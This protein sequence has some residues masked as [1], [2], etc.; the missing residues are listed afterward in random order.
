VKKLGIFYHPTGETARTLAEKVR[1]RAA[2]DGITSWL[3]SPWDEAAVIKNLPGTDL[4]FCL[5]G[6]GT[7]LSA[8][9][10]V[11]PRPVPI[12]G[13]NLGRLGFLCELAP[14][15]T[16]DRLS[17]V[18]LGR[19]RIE[20]LSM[21]Q[22]DLPATRTAPAV[23]LHALNDVTITRGR[24]AR[25]LYLTLRVDGVQVVRIRADGFVIAT[26]TG[27]TGYN[28]SAGGPVLPPTSQEIVVTAVAPHLSR[29]RPLVLPAASVLGVTAD[30]DHE[31]IISLDGQVNRAL[32]SGDTVQIQ[33]SP[34]R[35]QLVRLGAASHFYSRLNHYLDSAVQD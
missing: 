16:I 5:G 20:E 31:A 8:A 12:L 24:V 28:L 23:E 30:F 25:P 26:A 18:L 21:L 13:V 19:Y 1:E 17:E 11:L 15:E 29:V 32:E 33:Q 7:V 4:L 14:H 34:Y 6:D 27:S 10:S 2:A 35:A 3:S 22:A 9:R